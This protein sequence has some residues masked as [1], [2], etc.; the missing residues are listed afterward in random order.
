MTLTNMTTG[1]SGSGKY[2]ARS[3]NGST[4]HIENSNSGHSAGFSNDADGKWHTWVG[5]IINK[6]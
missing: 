2:F 4:A 1:G 5:G 3:S 6:I